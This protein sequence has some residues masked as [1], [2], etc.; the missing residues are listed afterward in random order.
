MKINKNVKLFLRDLYLYDIEACHYTIMQKLDLDLS[1]IN[2]QD[3]T[4]RNIQIGK[5]MRKNPRL[6][7]LLQNTTRS[8]ID[9]FIHINKIIEDDIILRQY[10]GIIISKIL[11]YTDTKHIPLN[12]R[13]H[14]QIFISSIDR[15]KYIALTNKGEVIIKGIPFRY[16]E[17]DK[18]Y[19]AIC[20]INY[21]RKETIFRY[22]QRIKDSIIRSQDPKLFA[23]P[24]K[25]KFNIFLKEYGQLEVSKAAL[26]IMDTEDIDKERYFK[27]YIEPF[28][29]SVVV[30]FVR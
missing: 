8:V 3:K 20:K 22:L 9:E 7:S 18:I 16:R 5:M 24:T 19:E 28:T 27:F 12:I 15:Q 17:M 13:K 23:I 30:Q 25:D 29:K 11:Q 2:R 4:E 21:A 14:F 1:H 6:T 26:K 10:D